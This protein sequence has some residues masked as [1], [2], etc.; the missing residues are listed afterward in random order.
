MAN[1]GGA[2]APAAAPS[3][4]GAPASAPSAPVAERA[5]IDDFQPSNYGQGP[6]QHDQQIDLR[7]PSLV[8][9]PP[10][11]WEEQQDAK[12]MT[13]AGEVDEYGNFID[14]E[15]MSQDE[16]NAW[17]QEYDQ[18]KQSAELAE[19]LQQKLVTV[20]V[21][22][23]KFQV[24]VS[25]AVKG[26]QLQSYTTHRLRQLKEFEQT[27]LARENGM[28]MALV[29][30]NTSQDGGVAFYDTMIRLGTFPG[31][32]AAAMKL[33]LEMDAERRM[34]PEQRQAMS[35]MRSQKARQMQLEQENVRLRQ[36]AERIEQQKPDQQKERVRNQIAGLLPA[37]A[38]KI[39]WEDSG[40]AR[41]EFEYHFA[42]RMEMLQGGDVTPEFL[43]DVMLAAMESVAARDRLS[44]KMNQGMPQQL[45]PAR[46]GTAAPPPALQNNG[47]Y[48]QPKRARIEDFGKMITTLNRSNPQPRGNNGQF[49][50]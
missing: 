2:A 26:Y 19:P 12:S 25:E 35:I 50:R 16:T 15:V 44:A 39:G 24:P 48:Q 43:E 11:G 33:G 27:L 28:K 22:G 1:D 34:S 45:P 31:F 5:R 29:A 14:A 42:T 20:Q 6:I 17:R 4:G 18:W 9:R 23:Q 7:D 30:M 3:G 13:L 32:R 37:I 36:I 40:K 21:N 8:G 46:P 38:Q 47:T 41:E 10:E 49:T